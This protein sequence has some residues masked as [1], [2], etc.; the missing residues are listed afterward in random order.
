MYDPPACVWALTISG[1][2]AIA[3]ATCI[4]LYGGAVRAGLGRRRAALLGGAAA[5][6]LHRYRGDRGSRLV[7]H[8]T[9]PGPGRKR[10]KS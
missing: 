4:A 2:A 8:A 6:A 3:T 1:P 9:Q 7:Q 10:G 5:V